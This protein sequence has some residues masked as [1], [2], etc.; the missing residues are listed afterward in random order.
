M[1]VVAGLPDTPEKLAKSHESSL[2]IF[3][4]I[5]ITELDSTDRKYV[6]DKGLEEGNKLNENKTSIASD[7]RDRIA[8]L[9]KDTHTSSNNSRIQRLTRTLATKFRLKMCS[10]LPSSTVAQS[11]QSVAATTSR[12]SMI[13][14]S[15]T[16][17]DKC[18]RSWPK[19]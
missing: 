19:G 12:R 2:R 16:N 17:T 3:T 18:C 4:H 5:K 13:E 7:A 8:S 11:M 1:F 6:I 15:L 10:M 14:S 9:S